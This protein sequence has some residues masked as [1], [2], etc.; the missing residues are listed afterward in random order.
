MSHIN[1]LPWREEKRHHSKKEFIVLISVVATIS[2]IVICLAHAAIFYV[3]TAQ[4]KIDIYLNEQ[5]TEIK[6]E[7]AKGQ[8]LDKEKQ[9]LL[10]YVDEIKAINKQRI[11][12]T[13][14]LNHLTTAVPAGVHLTDFSRKGINIEINGV[15]ESN[16]RVSQ[17]MRNIQQIKV[18]K[19]AVLS[20][21]ESSDNGGNNVSNFN[22]QLVLN[23]HDEIISEENGSKENNA[24]E[25]ERQH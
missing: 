21:I 15:A 11:E 16:T 23:A 2:V 13:L 19:Q 25:N 7:I 10:S 6:A 14:I 9:K 3:Y 17:L 4:N 12:T 5:L 20:K 18:V 22:I 1:L 24:K 8:A